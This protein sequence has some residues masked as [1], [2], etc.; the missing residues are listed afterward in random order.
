LKN[1]G[2]TVT[3]INDSFHWNESFD[4]NEGY[5]RETVLSAMS[6]DPMQTFHSP[7]TGLSSIVAS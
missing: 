7:W 2:R 5:S 4:T 1:I 3:V 6:P